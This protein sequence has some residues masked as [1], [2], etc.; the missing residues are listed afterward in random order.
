VAESVSLS[1]IEATDDF[2]YCVS[3]DTIITEWEWNVH[4]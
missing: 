4:S 2:G 3:I 1:E